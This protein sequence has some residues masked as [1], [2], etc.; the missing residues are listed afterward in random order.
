MQKQMID[1]RVPPAAA[2]L[3]KTPFPTV[4]TRTLRNGTTVYLVPYGT[5]PVVELGAVFPGGRS[6][7][8]AAA[9]ATFTGKMLQE[10]TRNYTGLEFARRLDHLGAFIGVETGY[11]NATV[12]LTSLVKH[13]GSTIPLLQEMLLQPI[14]PEKDLS[15]LK[16]RTIQHL[17]VENQK[18]GFRARKEFNRLVFGPDHPYGRS[19]EREDI[20]IV[21]NDMLKAYWRKNFNFR[22]L[23][24]VAV[25][26][27]DESQL[28]R[29]LEDHF[30][31]PDV[32]DPAQKVNLDQSYARQVAPEHPTGLRYFEMPDTM[33]ATVRIGH[34]GFSRHHS[35]Y[36]RMQVVNTVLG[37]YF[38]SRLMKNIRED[39]GYTYGIG[40]AWLG[41]R[42][43]GYFLAQTDVGNQYIQP[44]L[45][46]ME[47]EIHRLIDQ[48]LEDTELGLVK[49]YMLG[50]MISGRETPMQIFE[51]IKSIISNGLPFQALDD[52]FDI[53]QGMTTEEV[54]ELAAKHLQ[55]E[56]L[57]KVVCGKMDN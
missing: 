37:G 27:F 54:Q 26:R 23:R 25:G 43:G 9:I 53:I 1:R 55:P 46:E 39:K 24:L 32:A 51:L 22:N 10:G 8:P 52:K 15:K 44:T 13:L 16:T 12:L 41:M 6:F 40:S 14:F 56:K 5:Q 18:T 33:Q 21:E 19:A 11:E 50:R 2:P 45:D 30:G 36:Y 28:L 42:Y 38:G 29:M 34:R 48:G 47:K 35:D 49:N 7:E 57:L 4:H 20:R 17:D 3:E 31:T